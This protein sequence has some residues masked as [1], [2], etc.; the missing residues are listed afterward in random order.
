MRPGTIV[1]CLPCT[2]HP[3][4][5]DAVKWVP[6][7]DEKTPYMVREVSMKVDGHEG[8]SFEEGV[9]GWKNGEELIFPV[10]CVREILPPESVCIEELLL[11]HA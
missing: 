5:A 9:I 6:V 10:T 7:Q 11:Q 1:V 3:S 4:V 2:I 8:V